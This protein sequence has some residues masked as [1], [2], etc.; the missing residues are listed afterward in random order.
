MRQ[1]ILTV[2][3]QAKNIQQ[4]ESIH[5]DLQNPVTG[6][7]YG[8]TLSEDQNLRLHRLHENTAKISVCLSTVEGIKDVHPGS[9]S[10]I[11]AI[12]NG[13][14]GASVVIEC[15]LYAPLVAIFIHGNAPSIIVQHIVQCIRKLGFLDLQQD[16]IQE[17][18]QEGLWLLLF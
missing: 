11:H 10:S 5:P 4:A 3:E 9:T 12:V 18:E 8:Y 15:S 7:D 13:N 1:E 16:E 6:T 17:L 14:K 2:L